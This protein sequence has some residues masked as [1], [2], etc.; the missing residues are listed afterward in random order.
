MQPYRIMVSSTISSN[1]GSWHAVAATEARQPACT[2]A[3]PSLI[4]NHRNFR[5]IQAAE[6]MQALYA[7]IPL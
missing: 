4:G 7:P 2:Q 5:P 1:Q 6:A 3:A